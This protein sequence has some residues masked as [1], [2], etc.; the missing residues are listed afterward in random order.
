VTIASRYAAHPYRWYAVAVV[1]L[2]AT[3]LAVVGCGDKYSQHGKD[4]PRWR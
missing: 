4:S 3:A 2:L 1:L